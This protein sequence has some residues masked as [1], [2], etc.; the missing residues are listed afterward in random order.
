MIGD[1]SKLFGVNLIT[2]V[3]LQRGAE[4]FWNIESK[5]HDGNE[6]E[7]YASKTIWIELEI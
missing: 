7:K 1:H 2:A 5:F 4:S 3:A 6:D